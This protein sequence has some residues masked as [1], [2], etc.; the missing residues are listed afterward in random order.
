MMAYLNR[1]NAWRGSTS[2][3]GLDMLSSF[4]GIEVKLSNEI[5]AGRGP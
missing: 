1:V 5:L 2:A 3:I 4:V